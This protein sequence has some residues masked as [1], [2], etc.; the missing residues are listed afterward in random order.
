VADKVLWTNADIAQRLGISVERAR[1]LSRRE[2]FP[3][4]AQLARHFSL[5]RANDVEAWLVEGQQGH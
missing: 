3:A 1:E 4:P 5:W 2:D